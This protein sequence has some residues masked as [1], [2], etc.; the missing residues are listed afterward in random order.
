MTLVTRQIAGD[1]DLELHL[2]LEAIYLKFHYD[3]RRYS[4][5]SL[6]RRLNEALG[7]LDCKT[8]SALQD[9]LFH[10]E[11]TFPAL[12][13]YLTVPVSELFRDAAAFAV[14]RRD[15]VPILRTYPSVRVWVAGCSTGEEAYSY[16]MLLAEEGLL[17]NA[18]IYATDIN[19]E[20]LRTAEAGVY[21]MDRME[22]FSRNHLLSGAP[23]PLSDHCSAAYG[24]VVFNRSLRSK[25][26]FS[27]HSLATDG[28]FAE[29]QIVSCRNVL[30]YFERALQQRA[31]ELFRESLCPRGFL[32]LGAPETLRFT[33]FERDFVEI[34]ERWYQRC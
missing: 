34:A 3:F 9:R 29:L 24:S 25:I 28:V 1:D 16:A 8:L 27:D 2:L 7:A 19:S 10:D 11:A 18:I 33:G 12:M 5:S 31:L 22:A 17:D 32:G 21:P 6:K 30:I 15:I 4:R 14:L 13:R 26:V 20:S 23:G